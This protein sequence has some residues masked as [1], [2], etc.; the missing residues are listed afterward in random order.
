MRTSPGAERN[1]LAYSLRFGCGAVLGVLFGVYAAASLGVE[2]VGLVV[3]AVLAVC[4]A[5]GWLAARFGMRFWEGVARL[6][7]W[8]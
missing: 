1:A 3:A 6:R 4:L 7:R 5:C 2:D 8:Y